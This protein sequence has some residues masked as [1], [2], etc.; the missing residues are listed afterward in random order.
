MLVNPE[1]PGATFR[2]GPFDHGIRLHP[3]N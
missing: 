1:R 3:A 2:N